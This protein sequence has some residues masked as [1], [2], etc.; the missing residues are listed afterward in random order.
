MWLSLR[1]QDT[2]ASD[3]GITSPSFEEKRVDIKFTKLVQKLHWLNEIE[4]TC[5]KVAK[6]L[7]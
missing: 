1:S 3:S 7:I 2:D 4:D 5:A 6:A